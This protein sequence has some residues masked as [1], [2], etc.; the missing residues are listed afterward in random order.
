MWKRATDSAIRR[1]TA[2]LGTSGKPEGMMP[3]DVLPHEFD[4]GAAIAATL[5]LD[6]RLP[7]PERVN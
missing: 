3:H 1:R 6:M 2:P 5:L 7:R 4:L